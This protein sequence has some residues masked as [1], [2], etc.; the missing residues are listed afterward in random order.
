MKELLSAI[1]VANSLFLIIAEINFSIN[2]K[3]FDKIIE[4]S[5]SRVVH[6]KK[7]KL[8]E[9][10]LANSKN[11]ATLFN[12]AI[13]IYSISFRII[14]IIIRPSLFT[15]K[16]IKQLLRECNT[17]KKIMDIKKEVSKESTS[18]LNFLRFEADILYNW[19]I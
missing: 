9:W 7:V 17:S 16:D 2:F 8:K 6:T 18:T 12:L 1:L 13:T 4:P 14:L 15:L 5:F 10:F 19:E 3:L 11:G